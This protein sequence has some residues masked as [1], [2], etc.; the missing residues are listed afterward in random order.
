MK[1]R[2]AALSC[3]SLACLSY[4]AVSLA[5]QI[6][7][8]GGTCSSASLNGIYSVSITGRDVTPTATF[9][10]VLEGIGT[11]TFD[12]QSKV[13]FSLTNNTNQSS[14]VVQTWSGSY[15]LQADCMGTLTLTAGEMASFSLEAYSNSGAAGA[16]SKDYLISGQDGTYTFTG[17]GSLLPATSCSVSQL[18]GSY[19]FNGPGTALTSGAIS[20]ANNISGLLQFDGKGNVTANWNVAASGT[21]TTTSATGQYSV[22]PPCAGSATVTDS[23]GN[24]STLQFV[25]TTSNGSNFLMSGINP[26]L[27]F[28]GSGR[29]ESTTAP[30]SVSTLKGVYSLVMTGRNISSSGVLTGSLQSSGSANFDGAG[31]VTF[32]LTANTNSMLSLPETLGGTYTIASNCGGTLNITSGNAASFNLIA[33]NKGQSYAITGSGADQPFDY[34]LTGSGS[35]QPVSCT[36]NSVSGTYAFSGT[37][38]SSSVPGFMGSSS[39]SSVSDISGLLQFDGRGNVSGGWSVATSQSPTADT[40]TGQYSVTSTC[41]GSATVTDPSGSSWT[42]NFTVSSANGANFGVDIANLTSEFS[43]S[44][45]STFTYPGLAVVNGASSVAGG[46]PPGSIFALYGSDLASGSAQATRVPLPDS[47]LTTT[48]T[49]NG[50]AAPLF[51][52]SAGQIN[53]QMP[54][55]I[56][57]GIASVVVK[58][59]LESSNTVAVDVPASAVPGIAVQ[60][61]TNQAVVVNPNQSENTPA[62]PGHVGDTVV[63]YFTGGGPVQAAGPLVTGSAS[64]KGLSPVI[65]TV[66]V[67]VGGNI[68]PS[69][70]YTGLTPTLVGVYQVN[71]VIPQVSAGDRNLILTINGAASATTTISI[72]D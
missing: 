70:P 58:S 53:A 57:P 19:S 62:A 31:N 6:Q 10:K 20:G 14:G 37:G 60:Y 52:V 65:G 34:P 43:A 46:T 64:P 15:S 68:S 21:S 41:L 35:I 2:A 63:A 9:S 44:G 30:C 54:W 4:P 18:S 5:A 61:P 17:S 56:Q 66:Q 51:Y 55:D 23:S 29:T 27:M 3:F 36:V 11:V 25:V 38:N 7:I 32:S 16:I 48:V 12:G 59:G 42:L 50:E 45:H 49:I 71:F 67:T 13:V 22:S 72:A 1:I 24:V 69:V 40:V 33:Y 26:L 47:L 8:G 39:I 28:T